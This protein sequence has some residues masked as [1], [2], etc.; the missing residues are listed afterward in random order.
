MNT[1]ASRSGVP[2]LAVAALVLLAA[3]RGEVAPGPPSPT[4]SPSPSVVATVSPDPTHVATSVPS[5]TP[6]ATP[7]LTISEATNAV[8]PPGTRTGLPLVD[9]VIDAVIEG[10]AAALAA[11]A[12][13]TP[14]PCGARQ[15]YDNVPCPGGVADG[16]L[17]DATW[18]G[19][20]DAG[21]AGAEDLEA[22]LQ[23]VRRGLRLFGVYEAG[24]D[25]P[26]LPGAAYIVVLAGTPSERWIIGA[27]GWLGRATMGCGPS[28][29]EMSKRVTTARWLLAPASPGVVTLYARP[30]ATGDPDLDR[31]M[32]AI[33]CGDVADL[34]AVARFVP[35]PCVRPSGPVTPVD[36]DSDMPEGTLLDLLPA[37]ECGR[38]RSIRR[39]HLS[40]GGAGVDPGRL[41]GT[42]AVVRLPWPPRMRSSRRPARPWSSSAGATRFRGSW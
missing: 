27:G 3:C 9:A 21:F 6:T 31:A 29:T 20:C 17:V 13:F 32:E 15:G 28:L 22:S 30:P 38:D 2:L 26:F 10:D 40:P 37:R 36:C 8:Y 7:A 19:G 16:T 14:Y 25:Y 24:D 12:E 33:C 11:T 1:P 35:T 41:V 4:P 5:P 18:S 42:Y 34:A 23:Y 39:D